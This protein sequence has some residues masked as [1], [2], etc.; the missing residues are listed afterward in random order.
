MGNTNQLIDASAATG[1]Q[2]ISIAGATAAVRVLGG[3]AGDSITTGAGLGDV[4]NGGG[5]IDTITVTTATGTAF[6]DIQS[7]A[8]AHADA[9]HVDGFISTQDDFDYNGALS[10]GTKTNASGIASTEIASATTIAGALATAGAGDDLV[11]IATTD[12]AGASETAL[13]A[14]EAAT[15]VATLDAAVAALV[16]NDLGTIA[17]LDSVLGA[18]DFVLF[19]ISTNS[20]TFVLRVN[21]FNTTV[22]NTLT[23]DE[24]KIVGVF[25]GTLDLVAADYI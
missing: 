20:A 5:G 12:I 9:D 1:V 6:V 4:I 11:F 18:T 13:D 24:I 15:T 23:A 3:T 7:T 21:N 14:V 22:A 17:G 16:A 8:T 19:Q 25:D 10:N 2:T